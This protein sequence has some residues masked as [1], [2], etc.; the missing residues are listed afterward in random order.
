MGNWTGTGADAAVFTV[1][2]GIVGMLDVGVE[3][4]G[5]EGGKREAAAK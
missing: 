1:A 5:V 3:L 4:R 2:D